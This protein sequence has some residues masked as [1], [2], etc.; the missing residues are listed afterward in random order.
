MKSLTLFLIVLGVFVFMSCSSPQPPAP[1]QTATNRPIE[2]TQPT[3]TIQ[4]IVALSVDQAFRNIDRTSRIAL[5]NFATANPEISDALLRVLEHTLAERYFS[6]N[7]DRI[8]R[9]A[10]GSVSWWWLRSPGRSSRD[11]SVVDSGGT[12]RME[13]RSIY[14]GAG[15]GVRP[16][17]W[18]NL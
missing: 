10:N 6:S 5:V 1:Q 14:M 7:Q 13:G 15:N 3:Q 8:V 16:A 9:D 2:T 18:L 11:A 4:E 17:L 12:I